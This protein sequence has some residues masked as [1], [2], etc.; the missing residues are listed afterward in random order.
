[1]SDDVD[2]ENIPLPG[3]QG[4]VKARA[5]AEAKLSPSGI[6][7]IPLEV[8]ATGN[9]QVTVEDPEGVSFTIPQSWVVGHDTEKDFALDHQKISGAPPGEL[10]NVWRQATQK[11]FGDKGEG[12]GGDPSQVRSVLDD[13]N[14]IM[15]YGGPGGQSGED[16]WANGRGHQPIYTSGGVQQSGEIAPPPGP[17]P[18]AWMPKVKAVVDTRKNPYPKNS[19]SGWGNADETFNPKT[20]RWEKRL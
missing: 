12:F 14:D 11:Q 5:Q 3:M 7:G 17:V 1:M 4:M 6:K 13:Y 15:K 10:E 2:N 8:V 9:G 19:Y 18:G 16:Y 20:K